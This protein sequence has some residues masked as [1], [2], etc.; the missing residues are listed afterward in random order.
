MPTLES[1][2]GLLVML[3]TEGLSELLRGWVQG[4]KPESLLDAIIRTV[5][6]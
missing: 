1:S 6:F 3:F 2:R 5:K 4:F